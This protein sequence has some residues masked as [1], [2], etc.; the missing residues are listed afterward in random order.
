MKA[1]QQHVSTIGRRMFVMVLAAWIWCF[2]VVVYAAKSGLSSSKSIVAA[3]VVE[4]KQHP[5]RRMLTSISAA[6]RRGIDDIVVA[7]KLGE[8]KLRHKKKLDFLPDGVKNSIAS[9]TATAIVKIVLQP[10]DTIKTIQQARPN[11]KL[12]PIKAAVEV[13]KQR[14][15]AGLW[16]GVGI[17]VCNCSPVLLASFVVTSN[18]PTHPHGIA[19]LVLFCLSRYWDHHLQERFISECTAV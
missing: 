3:T 7:K 13:I 8:M 11:I 12:G 15:V 9:A 6:N 18:S 10:L 19:G 2:P 5:L 4:R 16:S 17:S 14:G 1:D